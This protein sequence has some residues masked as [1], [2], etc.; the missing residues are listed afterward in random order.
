MLGT[1]IDGNGNAQ[2]VVLPSQEAIADR[3]GTIATTGV[4]QVALAANTGRSGYTI[5]N[6]STT[7]PMYVNELGAASTGLGS[8]EIPP[9]G[10][11]PPNGAPVHTNAVQ[12]LGTAGDLY[13]ARE[14]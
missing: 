5:Q 2:F 11:F 9:G 8:F 4:S 6:R 12:I 1:I 10:F 14:W 3:S 13:T 7:N